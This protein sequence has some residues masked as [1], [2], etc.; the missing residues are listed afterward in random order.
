MAPVK[1]RGL[2]LKDQPYRETSSI[3]YLFSKE[4]GV[5][6]GIAKGVRS[7][8]KKG[9]PLERGQEIETLVYQKPNRT[10]HLLGSIENRSFFPGIRGN[11]FKTA[12]RDSAFELMLRVIQPDEPLPE[13]FNYTESFMNDLEKASSAN[14]TPYALW[15]FLFVFSAIEGFHLN[16]EKCISCGKSLSHGISGSISVSNGGVICSSCFPLQGGKNTTPPGVFKFLLGNGL[17]GEDLDNELTSGT[18]RNITRLLADYCLHHFGHTSTLK[19][20]DFLVSLI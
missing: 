18:K 12:I 10:L 19:S 14:C 5:I 2:V 17:S 11:M 9:T 4:C 16:V 6:H 13:L 1:T 20:L 7:G 3:V 8:G 15:R